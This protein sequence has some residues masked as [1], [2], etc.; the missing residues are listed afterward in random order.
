MNQHSK[1]F[2]DT[3]EALYDSAPCGLLVYTSASGV[4]YANH[5]LLSWLGTSL[6]ELV[7]KQ[8]TDLLDKG[9]KFY[10]QLFVE[11]S[12]RMHKEALEIDLS[13]K[14]A[15]ESFP[16]LFSAE[17]VTAAEGKEYVHAAIYKVAN[18]KKYESELLRR[19]VEAEAE[20]QLKTEAL[21]EVAFDQAHLVR[22][23]LANVLGLVSLIEQMEMPEEVGSMVALLK[24]SSE[25][26]DNQVKAIVK[27]ANG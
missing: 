2:S 26:L 16:A 5:R 24:E 21:D 19:K 20:N 13:I 9:G 8:F 4:I 27:K 6:E 14:G 12:L 18:R 10:Y 11:P 23:P 17:V 1:T 7:S 3:P 22:A 25:Q 15:V